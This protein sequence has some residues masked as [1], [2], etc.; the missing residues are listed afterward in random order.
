MSDA[1]KPYGRPT[2]RGATEER[3]GK[4]RPAVKT[5]GVDEPATKFTQRVKT[6]WCT[7]CQDT[8]RALYVKHIKHIFDWLHLAIRA[9]TLRRVVFE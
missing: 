4:S 1:C 5:N 6:V 2:A 8:G 7:F 9:S 3:G